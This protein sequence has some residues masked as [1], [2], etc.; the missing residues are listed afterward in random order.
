VRHIH[1]IAMRADRSGGAD[2]YTADLV[3]RLAAR[4]HQ[5]TLLCYEA[6]PELTKVCTFHRIRRMP[7]ENVRVAWRVAPLL[8]LFDFARSLE[9]MP[10]PEP[11]LIIGSATQLTWMHARRFRKSALLYVPHSVVAPLEVAS[12]PWVSH[13]Q[14]A[15]SV[16]L[17]E[18][19]E[20]AV[21]NRAVRTIRFTKAGCDAL[22]RHYG[23][24]IRP[25]FN[26]FPV[27]VRIPDQP[28]YRAPAD[29]IRLLSVGRLINTKN[30]RLLI[31]VLALLRHRHW[32]LDVVGD[33]PERG[34]LEW[35]TRDRGLSDRV[36]FH[37]HQPDVD[38]WYRTANLLVS[39]SRLEYSP[40]V[41][42]EAMSYGVPTLS[43]APDGRRYQNANDEIVA[44]QVD[45]FLAPDEERFG[46]T[47]ARLLSS[48]AR[49]SEAGARARETVC[50]RHRWSDH[51]E[52]YERLFDEVTARLDERA[53]ACASC[54]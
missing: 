33:G 24:R 26:V 4:G 35:L 41:L 39:T 38:P 19:A 18:R 47:L 11:E 13:V 9:E 5:I 30:V 31:D 29:D 48:T 17:Y 20:R 45:G 36:T 16:Q 44:D 40:L 49:L 21:L 51:I 25:T 12:Y 50:R 10:L 8:S 34:P 7:Y 54:S 43:I 52:Q 28:A 1:V 2:V 42:L 3:R 15:A 6:E 37:G 53:V 46:Q 14:R 22:L 23:S 27:G 32:R